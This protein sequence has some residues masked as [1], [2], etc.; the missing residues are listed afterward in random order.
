MADYLV[1]QIPDIVNDAYEDVMG[2]TNGTQNIDTT[3]VV[4]LGKALSS[5]DLLDKWYG[6]LTNRIVKT[7]VFA[8]KYS[9]DTRQ[10]L[11]DEHTWGAFVQKLYVVAPDAVENPAFAIPNEG[12]YAQHSP[13]DVETTLSVSSLVY[14]GE[15]TWSYEF[16]LPEV[17]IRKAFLSS[18]AMNAFVDGQFIAVQNKIEVTKESLI[19]AAINTGIAD[20]IANGKARNLLSEYNTLF[21]ASETVATFRK[22]KEC[23][24]WASKEINK[25]VKFMMKPSVNFNVKGYETFSPNPITE[26][27]ADFAYDCQYNLSADTFHDNLVSLPNYSEVAFWQSQGKTQSF[28]DCSKIDIT[29]ESVSDDAVVQDG[30]IACI[31]DEEYAAAYFG[32]EYQWSMPNPRDRISIHGYQYKKGYAV[33][34]YAN[35]L[36]F[37][38][39]DAGTITVDDS[40]ENVSSISVSP[41][42]AKN[43]VPITI[44]AQFTEGYTYDKVTVN[45]KAVKLSSG[46]YIYTPNDDQDLVIKVTSKTS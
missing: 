15:G 16:I 6:A 10:I 26:V 9:A 33:D 34:E 39:S 28:A 31:R 41:N 23:L 42:S 4:S 40:D 1:K 17:Q 32:D 22:K 2:K 44:T 43:G 36:V 18:E 20:Q 24:A 3:D 14:G 45:G 19:N 35:C 25:A 30:I 27:L 46:E 11:K 21:S 12:T 7:V 5:F 38:L 8:R 13:Y 29:N 37:I